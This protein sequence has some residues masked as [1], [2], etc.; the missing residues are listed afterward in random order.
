MPCGSSTYANVLWNDVL[1]RTTPNAAIS[2]FTSAGRPLAQRQRPA[3]AEKRR[4]IA[5]I[6]TGGIRIRIERQ[7]HQLGVDVLRG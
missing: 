1:M 4:A 6:A 7:R 5:A 2:R 3:A